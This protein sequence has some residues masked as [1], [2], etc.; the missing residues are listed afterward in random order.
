MFRRKSTISTSFF[1]EI[2]LRR[3]HTGRTDGRPIVDAPLITA[4]TL[5]ITKSNAAT[6][7]L[8]RQTIYWEVR[9]SN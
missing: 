1:F 4:L 8:T 9:G 3:S 6:Q 7:R 2:N 5:L